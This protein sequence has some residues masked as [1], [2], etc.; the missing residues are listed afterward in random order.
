MIVFAVVLLGIALSDWTPGDLPLD[1]ELAALDADLAQL[2]NCVPP[3]KQG[4]PRGD[5]VRSIQG[6]LRVR[7]ALGVVGPRTK[8]ALYAPQS[9]EYR[10][11]MSLTCRPPVGCVM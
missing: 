7:E 9:P 2:G 6:I 5:C 1:L 10:P 11:T 3:M 4:D 8:E